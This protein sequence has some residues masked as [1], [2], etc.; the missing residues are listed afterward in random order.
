MWAQLLIAVIPVVLPIL[1][2]ALLN[3]RYGEMTAMYG[4][5][6]LQAL[7]DGLEA[8]NEENKKPA[9]AAE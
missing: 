9:F 4:P 6:I 1:M 2:Q 5:A 7:Q 8:A 3:S